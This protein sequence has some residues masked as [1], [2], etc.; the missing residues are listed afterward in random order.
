MA[1]SAATPIAPVI[2]T[3]EGSSYWDAREDC[4]RQALQQSLP[5]LVIAGRHIE[6]DRVV[7]DSVLSTMNGFVE[8]FRVLEQS[9]TKGSVRLKAE[10]E[11][12]QTD[13]E[14]FVLASG[15]GSARISS[16]SL[17]GEIGRDDLARTSR[18]EILKHLFEG[19]PT[20]AFDVWVK[21]V[22]VDPINRGQI[23]ATVEVQVN[24]KFVNNL[25]N[26]LRVIGRP[27]GVAPWAETNG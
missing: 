19:F 23:V 7:R 21:K 5:Q 10:V 20:K 9:E 18:S 12:S 8:S 13:I 2:V 27:G 14:N 3:G 4:V 16:S 22:E 11:I 15:K 17:L 25:K 6:D 24:K 1:C 26:G